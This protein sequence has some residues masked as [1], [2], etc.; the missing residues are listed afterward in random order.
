MDDL[1]K[2]ASMIKAGAISLGFD[3][4]GISTAVGLLHD[5]ERLREWLNAGYQGSMKYMENHFDKRTDPALLVDGA[6]SVIS[7]I[8]NYFPAEKQRD[9]APLISKYAYGE[10]YHKVIKK[11]L[12]LLLQYINE[13]I[14]P[15]RGRAFVD[16]AP[17][18]DRAWAARSGLGWI[19][20]NSNLIS[21]VY[22][23]FVFIGSLMVDI[24]LQPDQP[25]KNRCGSCN[26]CMR[27]CPPQAIVAP[28]VV[29]SGK[30]LSYLTIEHKGPI[31]ENLCYKLGNRLYGCDVCQDVCPWNTKARPHSV[32]EF[33]PLP[34]LLEMT[35]QDWL[36]MDREKFNRLFAGSALK[37]AGFEG[38]QRNIKLLER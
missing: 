5:A 25:V 4:C 27:A 19:G 9:D 3:G 30:C 24:P 6:K 12:L 14:T 21:P 28:G 23:S 2:H 33:K 32:S 29:D 1:V 26:K 8:L 11:K 15:A 18:L 10:D 37:R 38:L 7:V 20:K 34:G 16:S 35:C 31:A 17:V 22:G 13:K 36:G